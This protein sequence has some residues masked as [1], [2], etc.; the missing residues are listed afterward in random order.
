MSHRARP[1]TRRL[2]ALLAAGLVTLALAGCSAIPSAGAALDVRQVTDQVEQTAPQAPQPGQQPDQIVRGFITASARPDRDAAAGTSLAA[3]RQYLT[4]QA[5]VGWPSPDTPVL[6]L[7]DGYRTDSDETAPGSVTVT[8]PSQGLLREDR[9]FAPPPAGETDP[10]TWTMTLQQ[11]DGEWRISNPPP[12]LLIQAGDFAGAYQRKVVYFLD[13]S[14]TVVVPDPRYLVVS[15]TEI[16]RADRLMDLLLDGPSAALDGAAVSQFGPEAALRSNVTADADG[17]LRVDLTGVDVSTPAL[18]RALAAQ[19]VWT[20][21]TTSPR[22]AISVD[23]EPLDPTQLVYTVATVSS[24]DPDRVAGTGQVASD[25]YYVDPEG[26]VV[27]LQDPTLE[28][29]QV[30]VRISAAALSAATGA[31]AAVATDPQGGQQL[32][33]GPATADTLQAAL[34]ADTL[35]APVFSRTGDEVWVV[36]NGATR[37]EVYRVATAVTAGTASRVRVDS[38]ALAGIGAVTAL[39]LSPDGVRVAVV[40]GERLWVGVIAP[41]QSATPTDTPE[42]AG[43][44]PDDSA[45]QSPA[46]VAVTDLVQIRPDLIDVGAVT[47][48]SSRELTVAGATSPVSRRTLF[49]VGVDGRDLTGFTTTGIFN[50][51]QSLAVSAGQPPLIGFGDRIWQLSGSA[52]DGQWVTP[53]PSAPSLNGSSPFYP[54]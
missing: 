9:S 16:N 48:S 27:G 3:A 37:P 10:Y 8:G 18:R 54:G 26:D 51:V 11:I 40:A 22:I 29:P 34:R 14:G 36:Q 25:P 43:P 53:L 35:T 30:G 19:I 21:Y 5:Q 32:L 38:T 44:Q 2:R 42:T 17:V 39:A 28:W 41:V 15:S 24:F 7:A 45:T 12:Q 46:T 20:L 47:F 6:L 4:P 52:T 13:A 31:E 1:R 49:S 50:D 23:G 33:I